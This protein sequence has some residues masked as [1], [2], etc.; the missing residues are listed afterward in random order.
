LEADVRPV[1]AFFGLLPK[2][3]ASP[4]NWQSSREDR[5]GAA[6]FSGRRPPLE[7]AVP[8]GPSRVAGSRFDESP[9]GLL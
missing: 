5:Q 7:K 1:G 6:R 4:D 8:A 9:A 2:P 3:P